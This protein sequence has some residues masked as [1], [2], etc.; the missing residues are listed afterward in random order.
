MTVPPTTPS[1]FGDPGDLGRRIIQRRQELG[2]GVEELAERAGM[3]PSYLAY[4]ERHAE[5]RPGA[6]ACA[7]LAAALGTSV[8][9]LRGGG[10][11]RPV[12][13]GP[14]AGG[15]PRL[16]ALEPAACWERLDGGG[17]GRVIFDDDTGPV[18][19]PVNYRVVDGRFVVR[20]GEGSLAQAVRS[21]R[22]VSLE[23]D[24]LDEVAGVGWSVLVRGE[25]TEVT[26][27]RELADLAAVPIVPWAGGDR[28]VTVRLEP[29]QLT[30]RQIVRQF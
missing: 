27:P 9:W 23:V 11:D 22:P 18:A 17:V 21:H 5:A 1:S 2:M 19:L 24:H 29:S 28:H 16:E 20:T 12:G 13:A 26:D 8:A 7:R 3:H 25:A 14:D 15:V 4:V 10:Q 6:A 30:G